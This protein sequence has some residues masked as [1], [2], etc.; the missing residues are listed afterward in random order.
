[1]LLGYGR[2]G[3]DDEDESS[4]SDLALELLDD[5]L[6]G[7]SRLEFEQDFGGRLSDCISC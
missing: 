4:D 6:S 3:S 2:A 1:M 7:A 5:Y